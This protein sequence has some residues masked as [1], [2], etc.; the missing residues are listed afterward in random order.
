M[1]VI[2][3]ETETIY[4]LLLVLALLAQAYANGLGPDGLGATAH[5]AA[6][7]KACEGACEKAYRAI[8]ETNLLNR[9][10]VS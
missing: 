1:S 6:M 8:A 5:G 3:V 4:T 10:R 7:K 2:L 9:A